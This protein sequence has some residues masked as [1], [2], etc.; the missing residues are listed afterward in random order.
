MAQ[1]GAGVSD[2]IEL[3]LIKSNGKIIITK[4]KY[5]LKEKIIR[6]IHALFKRAKL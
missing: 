6:K 1:S 5:T 2:E 4:S 3:K